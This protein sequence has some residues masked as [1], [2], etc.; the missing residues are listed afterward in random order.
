MESKQTVFCSCPTRFGELGITFRVVQQGKFLVS[1]N[2]SLKAKR[3]RS[4][5][6]SAGFPQK[7]ISK[8]HDVF[9]VWSSAKPF[10]IKFFALRRQLETARSLMVAAHWLWGVLERTWVYIYIYNYIYTYIIYIY[11]YIYIL[12]THIHI[13]QQPHLPLTLLD[14]CVKVMASLQLQ[15]KTNLGFNI[16]N[17]DLHNSRTIRQYKSD[18]SVSVSKKCETCHKNLTY[19]HTHAYTHTVGIVVSG[20]WICHM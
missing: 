11:I 16:L 10:S 12:H 9:H 15:A 6:T 7:P 1:L 20:H 14:L 2:Q 17:S 19:T 8:F 3:N 18:G 13:R 4:Y 5:V